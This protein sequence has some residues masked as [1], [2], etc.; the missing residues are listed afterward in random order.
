MIWNAV[1]DSGGSNKRDTLF[2]ININC[3]FYCVYHLFAIYCL[4]GVVEE[5]QD[6]EAVRKKILALHDKGTAAKYTRGRKQ[7]YI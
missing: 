7:Q 4:K 6:E 5:E 1:F 3:L 2:K